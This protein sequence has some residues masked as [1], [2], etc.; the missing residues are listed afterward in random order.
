MVRHLVR[1][2]CLANAEFVTGSG[3]DVSIFISPGFPFSMTVTRKS[4]C[5]YMMKTYTFGNKSKCTKDGCEVSD[6]FFRY[7]NE[8]K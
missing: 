1:V 2:L 4:D 8:M 5:V 6:T 3:D 7:T